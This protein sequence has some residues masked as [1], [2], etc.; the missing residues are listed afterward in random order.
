MLRVEAHELA[1][2]PPIRIIGCRLDFEVGGAEVLGKIVEAHGHLAHYRE[3]AA[4]SALERPEQI[5]IGACIRDAN[6]PVGRA[7]FGFAQAPRGGAK[8]LRV[9][10]EPATLD[11]TRHAY[12]RASSAL[13]VFPALGGDRVVCLHPDCSGAQGHRRLGLK[14]I[15][16]TLR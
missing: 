6:L 2:E 16:A 9:T 4:A 10:S 1:N 15:R 14:Y 7:Y 12:G 13:D 5:G 11:Q 3:A 8:V